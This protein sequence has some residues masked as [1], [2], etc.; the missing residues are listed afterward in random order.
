MKND[1][2]DYRKI[3]Q[4]SGYIPGSDFPQSTWDELDRGVASNRRPSRYRY[5][6]FP[7]YDAIDAIAGD[8]I[9]TGDCIS[10]S[11]LSDDDV[12]VS[13]CPSDPA[14]AAQLPQEGDKDASGIQS[15]S[16]ETGQPLRRAAK[17]RA[18]KIQK[19]MKLKKQKRVDK[20][21]AFRNAQLEQLTKVA[22]SMEQFVYGWFMKNNL[23]QHVRRP[24]TLATSDSDSD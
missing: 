24:A 8:A 17:R 11:A 23:S 1:Y 15:D 5:K 20:E 3:V 2:A 22:T 10:T 16:D 21:E 12:L 18:A 4:S 13:D 6:P 14:V 7:H 19:A 9:A